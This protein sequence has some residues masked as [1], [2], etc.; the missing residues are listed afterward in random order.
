M[1]M[2]KRAF[3]RN[4]QFEYILWDSWYNCLSVMKNISEVVIKKGGVVSEF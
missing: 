1:Q 3:K 2:I 4:F